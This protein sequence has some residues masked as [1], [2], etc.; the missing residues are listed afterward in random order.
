M[1][2]LNLARFQFWCNFLYRLIRSHIMCDVEINV[3]LT[4]MKMLV[5]KCLRTRVSIQVSACA[6]KAVWPASAY[7]SSEMCFW[8]VFVYF[9]NDTRKKNKSKRCN[10]NCM[11]TIFNCITLYKINNLLCPSIVRRLCAFRLHQLILSLPMLLPPIELFQACSVS[12]FF[13]IWILY[14]CCIHLSVHF[15]F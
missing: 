12:E 5:H 2:V 3:L 8:M 9:Q 1:D 6:S 13:S 11:T 10:R 7:E 14:S 4:W 15:C